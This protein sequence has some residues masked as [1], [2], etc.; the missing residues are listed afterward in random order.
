MSE[1][2]DDL[3]ELRELLEEMPAE[4]EARPL[5]GCRVE[6]EGFALQRE[7]GDEGLG[8]KDGRKMWVDLQNLC[9]ARPL[10]FGF[11]L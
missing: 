8:L 4:F 2:C 10:C 7:A 3:F 5:W 9:T 6:N 1:C 11:L